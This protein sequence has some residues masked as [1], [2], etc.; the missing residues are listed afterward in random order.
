MALNLEENKTVVRIV[1]FLLAII[2]TSITVS[3]AAFVDSGYLLA[4][5]LLPCV[6]TLALSIIPTEIRART[7]L[8]CGVVSFLISGSIILYTVIADADKIKYYLPLPIY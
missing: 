1:T 4:L 5:G 8:T 6:I 2:P 3:F 7:L